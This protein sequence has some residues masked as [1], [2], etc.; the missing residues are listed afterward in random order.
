MHYQTKAIGILGGT[1]DPIHFGHL[2]AALE[3]SQVLDLSKVMFIP[4][5]QPVHRKLPL[6][7]PHERLA[8]VRLAIQNEPKLMVNDC[9]I[10]RQG[11]SYT[12]DTLQ[13]LRKE[14]PT[15]PF[16]LIMGIDALLNFPSWHR[17]EEI[18]TLAHLIVMRR[19]QYQ[20]PATGIVADLLK[21]RLQFTA[22]ALYEPI[23]GNILLQPV[24]L[25]EI[26]AT[27]IRKLIA[28]GKSPR[29]LLPESVF[30]YIKQHGVYSI[31]RL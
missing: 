24:T 29:F 20:L 5:Y 9:E 19:P 25:L 3:I 21:Q 18:L 22:E 31:S 7:S 10:M 23:A 8:M 6:A 30:N 27:E 13:H 14:M 16:C 11:P 4:C 17:W 28:A 1:F 12:I 2:R 15:T 26:S